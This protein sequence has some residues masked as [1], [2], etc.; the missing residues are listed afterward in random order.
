MIWPSRDA[1]DVQALHA[2]PKS[3]VLTVPRLRGLPAAKVQTLVPD[4]EQP[5]LSPAVWA[6]GRITFQLRYRAGSGR[7]API[8]VLSLGAFG[9]ITLKQA[10]TAAQIALGR[11]A[12][13]RIRPPIATTRGTRAAPRWTGW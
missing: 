10:R 3:A 7:G 6:S 13:G 4:G 9:E 2:M 5:S 1:A 11:V 12:L 8:R